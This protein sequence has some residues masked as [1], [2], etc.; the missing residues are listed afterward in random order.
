MKLKDQLASLTQ[1]VSSRPPL[2]HVQALQ[3]EYQNLELILQGNTHLT[4]CPYTDSVQ[5]HKEKTNDAWPSW[6][7]VNVGRK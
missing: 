5:G 2:E 3:K 6:I 7:K 1:M 4:A